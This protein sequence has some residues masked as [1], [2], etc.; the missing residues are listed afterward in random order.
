MKGSGHAES[1][2]RGNK[3]IG[4]KGGKGMKASDNQESTSG[5]KSPKRTTEYSMGCGE[6]KGQPNT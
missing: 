3:H 2:N 5:G 4:F 1:G 6:T